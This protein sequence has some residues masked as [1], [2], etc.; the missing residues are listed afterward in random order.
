MAPTN[1]IEPPKGLA[2]K[3]TAWGTS[4]IPPMTLLSLITALHLRPFQALP[5]LMTPLLALSSYLTLAGFKM[6]GAGMTAAWSGIY[7]LLAAR[8]GRGR[9]LQAGFR[10]RFLSARGAVRG[11]AMGVGAAN[12]V[13]GLYVYSTG[14]REREGRERREANRWGVY[15]D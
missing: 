11:V 12:T 14:D 7:V 4:A 3:L 10:Q 2:S 13:A 15:K 8:R 1:D 6:D 5:M 9:G